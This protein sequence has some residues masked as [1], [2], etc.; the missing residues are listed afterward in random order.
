VA[1]ATSAQLRQLFVTMLLY[2]DITD[3]YIFFDRVWKLLPYDIQYNIQKA[4]NC[5]TYQMPENDLRSELLDRLDVLFNKSG[6]NIQDFN[7]PQK[8]DSIEQ[9]G[10][11]HLIEE[12]ISYD[13]NHLL[14]ESETLIS[15]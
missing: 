8:T 7:L 13:V 3:E 2:C 11:N 10:I 15:H 6:G 12:E 5:P 9:S 1:W 4:L 14:D